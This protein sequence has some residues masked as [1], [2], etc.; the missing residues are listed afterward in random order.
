M[1]KTMSEYGWID[2]WGVDLQVLAYPFEI[3]AA[4]YHPMW[5]RPSTIFVREAL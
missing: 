3:Q 2:A 5:R 1:A 4:T